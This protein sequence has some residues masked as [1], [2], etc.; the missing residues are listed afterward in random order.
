VV[1][2]AGR[3][4]G[5]RAEI[6]RELQLDQVTLSS[7]AS[8]VIAEKPGHNIVG[9]QPELVVEAIRAVIEAAGNESS[10]PGC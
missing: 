6:N 1:L 5:R 8:Q 7:R 10:L 4:A 2:S 9:N 3:G